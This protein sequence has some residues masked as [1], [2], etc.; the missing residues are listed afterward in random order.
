MTKSPRTEPPTWI[1]VL[2]ALGVMLGACLALIGVAAAAGALFAPRGQATG[3]VALP[4]A[5]AAT[6]TQPLGGVAL[7]KSQLG[8]SVCARSA[9][10]RCVL[11]FGAEDGWSRRTFE[12]PE[13][14]IRSTVSCDDMFRI[15]LNACVGTNTDRWPPRNDEEREALARCMRPLG[16]FLRG[17]TTMRAVDPRDPQ[18]RPG[19]ARLECDEGYVLGEFDDTR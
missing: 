1:A 8:F 4:P 14:I 10:H 19:E 15:S 18:L 17:E 7:F 3:G 5:P 9:L 6:R 13:T 2:R 11:Q 12:F 16:A